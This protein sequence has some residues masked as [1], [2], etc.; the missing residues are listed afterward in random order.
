MKTQDKAEDKQPTLR[1]NR[2]KKDKM[3]PWKISNTQPNS[4]MH[5]SGYYL[6]YGE[7]KKD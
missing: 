6:D 3:L 7:G 1:N 4:D 2:D 5:P